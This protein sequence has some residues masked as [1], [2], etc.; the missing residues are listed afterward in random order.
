MDV[1][2]FD[3]TLYQG[4]STVDFFLHCLRKYPRVATTLPRTGLITVGLFAGMLEK[5]QFKG[6]LYRFLTKV[7]DVL[8][9][10]DEFWQTHES[11]IASPCHAQSGDLVISASPEF[12]LRDV[13]ARRGLELIAS[14]VDPVTGRVLGP[15]CHGE[16]KVRR[17]YERFP[18]AHVDRF[19]S[20]SKNDAPLAK[21][22]NRAYLVKNGQLK[23]WPEA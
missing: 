7:P 1:Y 20:D 12:L 22:A 17:L 15:N 3:G 9:E 13:C 16:E 23:S 6:T 14:P 10:V 2:D 21:L 5:T 4:D 8:G 19:F 18:N 11:K